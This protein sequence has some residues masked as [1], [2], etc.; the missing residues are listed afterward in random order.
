[1]NTEFTGK[2]LLVVGGTSGMGLATAKRV[3][4]NSGSVVLVGNRQEKAEQA[5]QALAAYGKVDIIVADLMTEAGMQQVM[6]TINAEH[7]DISLLVNAA[8]VFFPKP[9]IEH[10]MADYDLYMNLNR[11]TFFITREVVLNMLAAGIKGAIVNIGSMW[12]QQAIGATPSSAY[13]MAKAGL[14]A[15]TKNLAIELGSSGI[16]VNAVSPAV[17]HTPIYE[18]FIAKEEVKTVMNSFDSFHPI[19]RVGTPE[20]IAQTVAFLLSDSTG[21]VTGAVWDIDGGV[22]AGR[23]A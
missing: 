23:N 1:M 7:R 22:M 14:H 9:F 13:S 11:A 16:R 4:E 6:M 18:G 19:G 15:L 2:K 17:V 3:I 5:R 8:G 12:A 10:E 20:D 21:W